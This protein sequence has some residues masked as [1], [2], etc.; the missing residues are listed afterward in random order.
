MRLRRQ[1]KENYGALAQGRP[2]MA[3]EK[4][5]DAVVVQLPFAPAR[6]NSSSLG[7]TAAEATLHQSV[8]TLIKQDSP[9]APSSVEEARHLAFQPRQGGGSAAARAQARTTFAMTKAAHDMQ[10]VSCPELASK[11]S[12]L[13]PSRPGLVSRLRADHDHHR[14]HVRVPHGHG[15][16]GRLLRCHRQGQ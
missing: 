6:C 2:V 15:H 7:G 1:I 10:A 13:V 11:R 14:R 16:L 8:S 4:N 3:G 5:A 12:F 9:R